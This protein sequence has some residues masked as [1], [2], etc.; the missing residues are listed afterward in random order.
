M[1]RRD[2][3][4]VR[5]DSDSQ[6]ESIT[7]R[8]S[9]KDGVNSTI[10]GYYKPS[11]KTLE[12]TTWNTD[13]SGRVRFGDTLAK[14]GSKYA[15]QLTSMQENINLAETYND[16]SAQMRDKAQELK[17]SNLSGEGYLD[18]ISDYHAQ[19]S[20]RALSGV[21]N[22]MYAGRLKE[23]LLRSKADWENSAFQEEQAMRTAYTLRQAQTSI[24]ELC[25][26]VVNNPGTFE[27][28]MVAMQHALDGYRT[29]AGEAAYDKVLSETSKNYAYAYGMGMVQRDP[30]NFEALTN[31][32][33]LS[34]LSPGQIFALKN[35]AQSELSKREAA[36]KR[37]EQTIQ[38]ENLKHQQ[39]QMIL[40]GKRMAGQGAD[41]VTEIDIEAASLS[42]RNKSI[43]KQHRG[44]LLKAQESA[45]EQLAL[46]M[47]GVEN[48]YGVS[49]FSSSDQLALLHRIVPRNENGIATPK[50]IITTGNSLNVTASDP[51][52]TRTIVGTA[53]K[54]DNP[55][56]VLKAIEDYQ[57]GLDTNT[58]LLAKVSD[59]EE[60]VMDYAYYSGA[61]DPGITLHARDEAKTRIDRLSSDDN[62][63]KSLQNAATEYVNSEDF[64]KLRNSTW[65]AVAEETGLAEGKFLFF[66]NKD[67]NVPYEESREQFELFYKE[68]MR[69]MKAH[70]WNENDAARIIQ[71]QFMRRFGPS[72]V[73]YNRIMYMPPE[74]NSPGLS[75]RELQDR[76]DTALGAINKMYTAS[77]HN[78][79][80]HRISVG[81]ERNTKGKY[82]RPYVVYSDAETGKNTEN[83][84]LELE[85][86]ESKK[87]YNMYFI[88]K[89][90][91]Q[92][93]IYLTDPRGQLL[94]IDFN[95][96]SLHKKKRSK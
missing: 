92:Y 68:R 80:G 38:L 43:L 5:R 74:A 45:A 35:L 70:G 89:D 30:A 66:S 46:M 4:E 32:T 17:R 36:Q 6:A 40:M 10:I 34:V 95:D 77:K 59:D 54:S 25:L 84:N 64:E 24:N 65:D 67:K 82:I 57:Y 52:L 41:A 86:N 22:P 18:A 85:W 56:K 72:S 33:R 96:A 2:P 94:W 3:F 19:L 16:L 81:V 91:N 15:S 37:Y 78:V 50:D 47:D 26:N 21:Y 8:K 44:D 27:S 62:F 48:G 23:M 49:A 51:Q 88:T 58:K 13:V 61:G 7:A 71:G 87:A 20:E 31:D 79:L 11:Y 9:S 55:E 69:K 29:V 75:D 12:Y 60:F 53:M 28:G 39:M 14:I 83:S 93:K 76:F 73:V 42:P 63:R 90:D 1:A